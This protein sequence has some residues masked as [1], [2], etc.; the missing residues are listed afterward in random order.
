MNLLAAVIVVGIGA[1][2]VFVYVQVS[3]FFPLL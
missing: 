3:T 1:D 2:D